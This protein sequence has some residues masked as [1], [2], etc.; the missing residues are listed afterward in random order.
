MCEQQK[1]VRN[2]DCATEMIEQ[3]DL[4]LFLTI[5]SYLILLFDSSHSHTRTQWRELKS[6]S[7]RES[8]NFSNIPIGII[9]VVRRPSSC[10]VFAFNKLF[11]FFKLSC[12]VTAPSTMDNRPIYFHYEINFGRVAMVRVNTSDA[13]RK[14]GPR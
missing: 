11:Q 12:H 5:L 3:F 1:E 13:R 8:H 9:H 14:K 2:L 10:S 7:I 6:A 4:P